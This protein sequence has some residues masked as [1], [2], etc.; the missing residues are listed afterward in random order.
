M[1]R[2]SDTEVEVANT[3]LGVISDEFVAEAVYDDLESLGYSFPFTA[4]G[5]ARHLVE[6][7]GGIIT[8]RK[9]AASFVPGSGLKRDLTIASSMVDAALFRDDLLTAYMHAELY[10][11]LS[12]VDRLLGR[13]R[14]TGHVLRAGYMS[15]MPEVGID[16]EEYGGHSQ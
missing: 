2:H 14:A 9:L 8:R 16:P 13:R 5:D 15:V 4:K 6:F 12:P 11:D 10:D 7:I 3:L 1:A